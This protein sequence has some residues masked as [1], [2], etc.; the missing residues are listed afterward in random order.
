MHNY[1]PFTS[2]CCRLWQAQ[3]TCWNFGYTFH[4]WWTAQNL[5]RFS[6][7]VLY[8]YYKVD[9]LIYRDTFHATYKTNQ[10]TWNAWFNCRR[11]P[12]ASIFF[13][14]YK[15]IYSIAR[16]KLFNFYVWCT[17]R[18]LQI[19]WGWMKIE[20]YDSMNVVVCLEWSTLCLSV[21]Q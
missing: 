1:C 19:L 6:T 9:D 4:P 16:G 14:F 20:A 5:I 13:I 7:L 15:S 3:R 21:K 2:T 11:T 12:A 17:N 18:F 8:L 10:T